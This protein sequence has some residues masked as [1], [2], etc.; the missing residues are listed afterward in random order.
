MN[1][2]SFSFLIFIAVTFITFYL[3]G[4]LNSKFNKFNVPQWSVL[5]IASMVFLGIGRFG[6]LLYIFGSSLIVYVIGYYIYTNVDNKYAV[7]YKDFFDKRNKIAATIG[8]ILITSVLV[9]LKYFNFFS[10]N[11]LKIFGVEFSGFEFF[12]PLGISFYTF[13]LIAYLVDICN[14]KYLPETNYFKFSLFGSYFPKMLQGPITNIAKCAGGGLYNSHTLAEVDFFGSFRRFT[15]GMCK[16]VIIADTI[17]IFVNYTW[18]N[19]SEINGFILIFAAILY[20]IQLYCD[21]SGYIDMGLAISKLFGVEL[22]ENF[23]TPYLSKDVAEFWR[24]WHITLG[25]WLKEYIYFPL[26]GNRCKKIKWMFNIMVVWLVSGL[27]HG[28]NWTYVIWGIYFGILIIITSLIRKKFSRK[29]KKQPLISSSLQVIL[30]FVLVTFGWVF[31]R[32]PTLMD[33]FKYIGYSFSNM[34]LNGLNIFTKSGIS[35]IYMIIA[36]ICIALLIGTLIYKNNREKILLKTNTANSLALKIE[37]CVA[38]AIC[39]AMF[40]FAIILIIYYG[41]LGVGTSSFIYFE[42]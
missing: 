32:A 38:Y 12:I 25:A 30:T 2:L 39:I 19:Y 6:S 3:V 18:K 29:G 26:G 14:R 5:L 11:L 27:W 42:F 35:W 33:A 15:I 10:I 7:E 13:T 1:F 41:G 20:S 34:G 4:F 8:V 23:N 37:N 17:G 9:V 31:F 22:E 36:F 28:A 24:R 21:F 40:A 16:K